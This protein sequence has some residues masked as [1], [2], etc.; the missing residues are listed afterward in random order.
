MSFPGHFIPT[1]SY[2]SEFNLDNYSLTTTSLVD[3]CDIY[4]ILHQRDEKVDWRDIIGIF[5]YINLTTILAL[6]PYIIGNQNWKKG[7]VISSSVLPERKIMLGM[8]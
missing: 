5:V 4:Q 8:V 2:C 6:I 7:K 3:Y 1:I